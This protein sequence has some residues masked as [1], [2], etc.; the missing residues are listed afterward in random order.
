MS[1][2]VMPPMVS[3][4]PPLMIPHHGVE[5]APPDPPHHEEEARV[6][7]HLGI[8]TQA[9]EAAQGRTTPTGSE[10]AVEACP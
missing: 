1:C 5:L 2:H 10:E 7:G 4:S 8:D 6:G 9:V 3:S